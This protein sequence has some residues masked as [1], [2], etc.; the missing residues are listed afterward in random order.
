MRRKEAAAE[1]AN[2]AGKAAAAQGLALA[3]AARAQGDSEIVSGDVYALR[4]YLREAAEAVE[5]I[6]EAGNTG[7][8]L[9]SI[10][11]EGGER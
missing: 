3:L 11:G 6:L 4:G 2:V 10:F 7:A 8:M 1:L 5:R 9:A